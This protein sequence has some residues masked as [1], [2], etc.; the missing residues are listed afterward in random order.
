MS[1]LPKII[2]VGDF[3]KIVSLALIVFGSIFLYTDRTR[4]QLSD[5]S[6]D[7]VVYKLDRISGQVTIIKGLQEL[8]VAKE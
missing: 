5:P 6:P 8:P 3:V 7:N 4:Y 1:E 2:T